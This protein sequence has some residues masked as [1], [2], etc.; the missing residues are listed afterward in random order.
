MR[1]RNRLL[2]STSLSGVIGGAVLTFATA[3]AADLS[4]LYK[5]PPEAASTAPAVDGPNWTGDL[6]GGSISNE[7]VYGFEGA[8]SVPLQGQFGAQLDGRVGNLG[9]DAF[10][11]AGGHLFWRNPTQGL[12]G[13]YGDY[14]EWDRFGGVDVGRVGGEGAMYWGPVTLE[15]VAGVEFGNSVSSTSTTV[16]G[17]VFPGP[18]IT[19]TSTQGFDVKTRFFD[20]VKLKY[21]FTNDISAYVGHDYLGGENA[22]ALGGEYAYPL[23]HG[24]M[25]SAFVEARVGENNFHGIWG[26]LRLYWGQKDKPLEARQR[27]DDPP[28]WSADSLF[29]I[30]NNSTSTGTTTQTCPS[31]EIPVN[32]RCEEPPG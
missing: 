23:G 8:L 9:G 17:S 31:N 30:L 6:F 20:E 13:L 1:R 2:S 10:G 22:L 14:T 26:G 5:A 28:I 24:M 29:S 19:T 16:T 7:N 18:L 32:G 11:S 21:Y 27:Q 25:G 12:I 3:H 15:G 4:G